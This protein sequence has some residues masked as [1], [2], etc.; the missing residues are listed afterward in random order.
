[1]GTSKGSLR[2]WELA[3]GGQYGSQILDAT[4]ATATATGLQVCAINV[5]SAATFSILSGY[6]ASGDATDFRV[7]NNLTAYS[8]EPG[9]IFAPYGGYFTDIA[10][11]AGQVSY[12]TRRDD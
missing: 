8:V 5:R 9:M 6:A 10:I 4:S 1:M 12:Y 3:M 7:D 11:T 2:Y